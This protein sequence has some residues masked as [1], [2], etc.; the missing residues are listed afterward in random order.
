MP[1]ILRH[2]RFVVAGAIAA[3]LVLVA[4]AALRLAPSGSSD[5][6][7]SNGSSGSVGGAPASLGSTAASGVA[8]SSFGADGVGGAIATPTP[9]SSIASDISPLDAHRFL[10]RTG[11]MSLIVARGGVPQAAAR[12]VGLTTGYGGYVLTSQVSGTDGTSAPFA[13]VT[14]RVPAGQYDL[15]VERF[16]ALG[17]VQS[18]QT[19]TADVT[20]QYVDLGARLAQARRVDQRLL[21]FLSRATTVTEALAVQTRID[22]TELQV[23]ELTGQLK[24]VHEQVSYGTLTVSVSERARHRVA[25][26]KGGFLGA[27]SASW[28]HLVAGF[29]AIVVGLGAVLPFAVM[30]AVLAL[31]AWF[32]ARAAV[33]LR[34][35]PRLG[36]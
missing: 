17:R 8:K 34:H 31:A 10:V 22:A 5:S 13:D 16:G 12:I 21:G 9:A 14:V 6:N 24:A 27:L 20:S 33:R 3:A 25:T 36:Q 26:H 23:E 11:E 35:S 15:A 32:G 4:V 28:R 30:L 19:S 7:G 18:V 1:F 2:R 29:E